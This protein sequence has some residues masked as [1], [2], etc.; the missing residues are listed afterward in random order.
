MPEL[1]LSSVYAKLEWATTH[2]KAVDS[3]IDT[4]LNSGDN[5]LIYERNEDFTQHYLRAHMPGPRPDFQRWSL[6]IGDCVTNLRDALD[7]L[8]YAV[9]SL[10]T[11]PS[12]DKREKACFLITSCEKDFWDWGKSKLASVPQPVRDAMLKVQPFNRPHVLLPPLLAVLRELANGN[13][14]KILNMAITTPGIAKVEL[15][16]KDAIEQPA[17]IGIN[18]NDIEDGTTVFVFEVEK[19]D[20]S[21]YLKTADVALHV[22]IRHTPRKGS[23]E[24]GSDRTPYRILIQ[25]LLDEVAIVLDLMVKA[26]P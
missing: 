25:W 20:P 24:F 23:T 7:H 22:A 1:D 21:I 5:K 4:W 14:H 2:F 15:I 16:S 3:E 9:A 13:K 10:P 17:Q 18:R 6:I 11:S 26:V 19:P 12:P 8:I